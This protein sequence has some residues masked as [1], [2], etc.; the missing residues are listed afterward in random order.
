[1]AWIPDEW[2]RAAAARDARARRPAFRPG[3]CC[4]T[5][6][7]TRMTTASTRRSRS[8]GSPAS[9]SGV[10]AE[11]VRIRLRG[12]AAEGAG[13]R[14]RPAAAPRPAGLPSLAWAAAVRPAVLRAADRRRRPADRRLDRMGPAAERAG[15]AGGVVR[16]HRGLRP[17]VGA[18][19]AVA[20]LGSPTC[21]P[22]SRRRRLLRVVGPRAG[23]AAPARLAA[24][25]APATLPARA[26]RTAGS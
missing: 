18:D 1:M 19:A 14:R 7:R 20:G 25:A 17:G 15:E 26:T 24:V 10:S 23:G 4:S 5:P 2:S 3:R 12:S 6:S 9:G 8:S 11:V 13:E 22:G 16:P 21:G